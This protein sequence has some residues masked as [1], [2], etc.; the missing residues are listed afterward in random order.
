MGAQA[1]KALILALLCA[2]P[3]LAQALCADGS[4]NRYRF[5]VMGT[6]YTGTTYQQACDAVEAAGKPSTYEAPNKCHVFADPFNET[7][8]VG[9]ECPG[10]TD[11]EPEPE[12]STFQWTNTAHLLQALLIVLCVV[13]FQMGF[14]AGDKL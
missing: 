8:F 2:C 6:Y 3:V 7:Q 12:P 1:V 5:S 4:A 13:V 9:D 11:S 10:W 14:R